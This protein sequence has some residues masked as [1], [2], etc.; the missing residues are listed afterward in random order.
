LIEGRQ[1][2][3]R[4]RGALLAL[5]L[6]TVA[7]ASS[8]AGF[9]VAIGKFKL[10]VLYS[11]AVAYDGGVDESI[12]DPRRALFTVATLV[13]ANAEAFA[14]I[15]HGMLIEIDQREGRSE[16]FISA[17]E[18]PWVKPDGSE[19]TVI[20]RDDALHEDVG[21]EVVAT[22]CGRY[23]AACRRSARATL[24]LFRC[25]KDCPGRIAWGVFPPSPASTNQRF[26]LLARPRAAPLRVTRS[27]MARY[28]EVL[29]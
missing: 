27:Q 2:Q 8:A 1:V 16:S 24:E 11:V 18:D 15:A 3:R 26:G 25:A 5:L 13:Q 28:F 17:V 29:D 22:L 20:V 14:A 7:R 6:P 23:P 10:Q 19:I 12:R 21:T 4:L 9:E